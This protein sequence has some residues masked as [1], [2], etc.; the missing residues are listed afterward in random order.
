MM[1]PQGA[2]GLIAVVL[3]LDAC[4]SAPAAPSAPVT[5]PPVFDVELVS[6]VPP[7]GATLD[8]ASPNDTPVALSVTFAVTV[9]P[10]QAGN[11]F[12]TT[13]VQ[14]SQPPGSGF[15]VPVVTTSPFQPVTLVAGT[16]SITMQAFHTTN[17]VCYSARDSPSMSTSLDIEIKSRASFGATPFYGKVFPATF[18]LRCR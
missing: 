7:A 5:P 12:W 17:A 14:A 1:K 3:G 8:I 9:P 13:A 11:Y 6:S 10:G 18:G 16:Q 4:G 15:V 2:V